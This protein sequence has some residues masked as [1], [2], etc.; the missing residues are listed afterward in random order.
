MKR[1]E[2]I[3]LIGGAATSPLVAGAQQPRLPVIG[4]LGFSTPASQR[5]WVAPFTERLRELGWLE[6]RTV[7]VEYRW[8]EG[9]SERLAEFASEF[10]RLKVDVIL[11]A[12]TE[13]ALA[14]KQATTAIPIVFPVAGDPVG[15]GLITSLT[16][17]GGNVTGLSNQAVDLA[18]KRLEILREVLPRL[19]R[20]GVLANADYSGAALEIDQIETAAPRLQDRPLGNPAH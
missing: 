11:A 20:L 4:Y 19:S 16:R 6:G 15:T 17:P 13:A 18:A 2:F 8:A 9:F 7:T 12:G 14:A 10:V 1:R 3:T 5:A